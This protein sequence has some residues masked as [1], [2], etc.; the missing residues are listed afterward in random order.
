[1]KTKKENTLNVLEEH[2]NIDKKVVERGK[3]FIRKKV[4]EEDEQVEVPLSHEEVDVVKVPVN[5]YVEVAPSIRNEGNVTIIPVIREVLVMEKRLLL[6]EEVRITKHVIEKTEEH[7]VPLRKEEVEVE[8]YTR[9][10]AKD[11]S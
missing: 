2:V 6:V 4:F 1:M 9:N 10:P 3:V 7:T 5:K 8:R 11:F